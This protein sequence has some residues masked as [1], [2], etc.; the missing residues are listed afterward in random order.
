MTR[1]NVFAALGADPTTEVF[2]PLLTGPHTR[3]ERIVSLGQASPPGFWYDQDEAE[4]VV[5]L[6][7]AAVLEVAESPEP[8]RLGPGDYVL[9]PAH[10]RHRVAWTDPDQPTVW[11]AVHVREG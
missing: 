11:V 10:Q 6:Q 8:L 2:T 1:G 4:W 7:G 3:I 9:L 5:L